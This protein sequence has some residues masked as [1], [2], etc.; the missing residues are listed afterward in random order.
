MSVKLYFLCL[1]SKMSLSFL[2]VNAAYFIFLEFSGFSQILG[3]I[4]NMSYF[5]CPH[6]GEPSFIFGKGGAHRTAEDM[7]LRFVGEV[8]LLSN[9]PR[10]AGIIMLLGCLESSYVDLQLRLICSKNV[11]ICLINQYQ[12]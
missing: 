4:E 11:L 6:C 9:L 8:C 3:I 2:L 7:G 5:K 10:V 1:D 12:V